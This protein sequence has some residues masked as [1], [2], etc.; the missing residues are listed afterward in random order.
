LGESQVVALVDV[1]GK[2]NGQ[3]LDVAGVCVNR[4]GTLRRSYEKVK[5]RELDK[6]TGKI[7]FKESRVPTFNLGGANYASLVNDFWYGTIGAPAL[8]D[9]IMMTRRH[10]RQYDHTF[11]FQPID[12]THSI[13]PRA[14]QEASSRT[15][16]TSGTVFGFV[17]DHKGQ[18]LAS[19]RLQA[20]R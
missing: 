8:R 15:V 7:S 14:R 2:H 18:C 4:I 13:G 3:I 20:K 6:N 12:K 19:A 1:H 9:F 5:V 16:H 10:Q 17:I 11:Y